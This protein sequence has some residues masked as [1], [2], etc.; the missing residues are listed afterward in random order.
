MYNNLN[1][2]PLNIKC[3]SKTFLSIMMPVRKRVDGFIK[4]KNCVYFVRILN[5]PGQF[6]QNE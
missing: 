3:I 2:I 1:N 5:K 6:S 4:K